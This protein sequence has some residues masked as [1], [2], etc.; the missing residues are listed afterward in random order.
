MKHSLLTLWLTALILFV[1]QT[2]WAVDYDAQIDRIYY[3]FSG[4]NATVCGVNIY[5][6]ESVVIPESVIYN[7]VTY[8]VKSIGDD[9]FRNRT[10]LK[11]IVI[12]NSVTIIGYSAFYGCTGL[13]NIVIPNSVTYIGAYAF[14]DCTGLTNIVIPNS[15]TYIGSYAFSGC[16]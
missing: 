12:P 7:D 10:S 9:A 15:V 5:S 14:R 11:K 6:P 8:N 1:S 2:L 3:K 16:I 13:T 4:T